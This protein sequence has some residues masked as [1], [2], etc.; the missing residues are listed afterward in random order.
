MSRKSV[1]L[2][3]AGAIALIALIITGFFIFRVIQERN[4][5]IEELTLQIGDLEWQLWTYG[6]IVQ[7]YTLSRER[8]SGTEFDI[9]DVEA[10]AIPSSILSDQFITDLNEL[11]NAIYRI[12]VSPGVPLTRGLFTRETILDTDRF[13]DV[14]V[15]LFPI[16]ARAGDYFDLRIVTANGQ[17][18]IVLAK[19]RAIEFYGSAVR[20]IL[21]EE[22]LHHYQSALVD[23]FLNPGTFLYLTTYVEPSMQPRASVYYPVSD[24]VMAVMEINPNIVEIAERDLIARRREMFER[25][26]LIDEYRNEAVVAGRTEQIARIVRAA[27][28]HLDARALL[29]GSSNDDMFAEDTA[30]PEIVGQETGNLMST[31]SGISIPES[32]TAGDAADM[33]ADSSP[34]SIILETPSVPGGLTSAEEGW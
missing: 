25:G 3:V 7:V 34:A 27:Q 22:E 9:S 2:I 18:Y 14:V 31:I 24:L 12:D 17:D 1:I 29:G 28:N 8:R 16:G 26:L 21:S 23:T 5:N 11:R 30:I 10:M 19:K 6:D 20:M 15:D 33:Q 32:A 4:Q 13:H